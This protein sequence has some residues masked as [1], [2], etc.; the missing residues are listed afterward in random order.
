MSKI[1]PKNTTVLVILAFTLYLISI[2]AIVNIMKLTP[3]LF[4]WGSVAAIG[5]NVIFALA[6][7]I[8]NLR[9][10]KAGHEWD[11]Q[12]GVLYHGKEANISFRIETFLGIL[13]GLEKGIGPVK[14]QEYLQDAGLIASLDFAT[15]LPE[16]Y[17]SQVRPKT[18]SAPW[19]LL[20]LD[21]KL[22]EWADYDS[23]TGWGS[24]KAQLSNGKAK[25]LI[26]HNKGLF[27]GASGNHFVHFLAGYCE[28]VLTRI[29]DEHEDRKHGKFA[30]ANLVNIS[31]QKKRSSIQLFLVIMV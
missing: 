14:L 20:S 26:R 21:D 29:I 15:G 5:L 28:T 31:V 4:Q 9:A 7:R 8:V 17:D 16:I 30:R 19:A 23:G 2:F 24:I 3:T 27:S 12:T 10:K 22:A 1:V 18:Q 6:L 25:V 11:H 13:E